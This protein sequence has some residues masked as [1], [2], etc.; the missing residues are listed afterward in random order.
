MVTYTNLLF[1]HQTSFLLVTQSCRHLS[2]SL[3]LSIQFETGQFH[4]WPGVLLFLC[5]AVYVTLIRLR[6]CLAEHTNTINTCVTYSYRPLLPTMHL[7]AEN[8]S[9]LWHWFTNPV[10]CSLCAVQ[11]KLC[12]WFHQV[13][14]LPSMLM[15]ITYVNYIMTN[16]VLRDIYWIKHSH[17]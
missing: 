1:H 12:A 13:L 11:S 15:M 10:C 6:L 14:P 5:N 8:M 3:L 7:K 17:K 2:V 16:W 9:E 4:L